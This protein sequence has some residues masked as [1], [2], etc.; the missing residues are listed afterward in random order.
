M[1]FHQT[2]NE[3]IVDMIKLFCYVEPNSKTHKGANHMPARKGTKKSRGARK[4]GGKGTK[5]SAAKKGRG[6]AKKSTK[7]SSSKKGRAGGT[8]KAAKKSTKK[9]GKKAG[10]KGTK[11][12]SRKYSGGGTET[13]ESPTGYGEEG[14]GK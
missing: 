3:N 8:K 1:K 14:K 4:G 10:G 11:K 5:K 6:G 13:F 2:K 7:K 12:S 9:S